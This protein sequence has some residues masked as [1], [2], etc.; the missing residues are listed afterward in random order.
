MWHNLANGGQ[1]KMDELI[2]KLILYGYPEECAEEL[3]TMLSDA[4]A[5]VSGVERSIYVGTIQCEPD[6]TY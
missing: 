6:A 5:Y 4:E 2:E 3:V 1:S